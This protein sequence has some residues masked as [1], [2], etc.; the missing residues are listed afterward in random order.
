MAV[1]EFDVLENAADEAVVTHPY[2]L[3]FFNQKNKL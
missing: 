1:A 2:F 3:Y